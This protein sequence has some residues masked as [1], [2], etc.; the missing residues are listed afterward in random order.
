MNLSRL[1]LGFFIL[2]VISGCA[3][4]NVKKEKLTVDEP[5]Q[6]SE[7]QTDAYGQ[8]EAVVYFKNRNPMEGSHV[9]KDGNLVKVKKGESIFAF[10]RE[11]VEQIDYL[12]P[13]TDDQMDYDQA[14]SV[15]EEPS[16]RQRPAGEPSG[17]YTG[18]VS[19]IE[20]LMRIR[21]ELIR[22]NNAINR[23]IR[24]LQNRDPYPD[25]Y[26]SVKEYNEEVIKLRQRAADYEKK[27]RAFERELRAF[28]LMKS[29]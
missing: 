6:P 7:I 29:R 16:G 26:V 23:Q 22:E 17:N 1:C 4:N 13:E 20:R 11:T 18:G 14:E 24:K 27:R 19:S 12:E 25:P 2:L 10:P 8:N 9:W 28:N 3:G 5:L 21:E 15:V